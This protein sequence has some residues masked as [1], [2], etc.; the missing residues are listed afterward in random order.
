VLAQSSAGVRRRHGLNGLVARGHDRED[1]IQAG[2]LKGLGDVLVDV[3][4]RQGAVV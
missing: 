1:L 4:D 2:D 3:D